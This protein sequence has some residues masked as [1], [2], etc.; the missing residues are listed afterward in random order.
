MLFWK[1]LS[2]E[3]TRC[4]YQYTAKIVILVE[5]EGKTSSTQVSSSL[6]KI[7]ITKSVVVDQV[8]KILPSLSP[9]S[10]S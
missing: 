3:V 1:A 2:K 7:N 9:F 5:H 10:F 4:C 8:I 6:K